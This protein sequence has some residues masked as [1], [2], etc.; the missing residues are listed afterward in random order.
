MHE[1]SA[2]IFAKIAIEKGLLDEKKLEQARMLQK[3]ARKDG[4]AVPLDKAC[5]E[6]EILTPEQVRG[7]ER[8]LRYYVARKADKI[9]A[10][11]ATARKFVDADTA[12][13]CLQK[14]HTEFYKKKRL[15]RLSKLLLGL[16]A[17]T[18]EQDDEVRKAVQG[19]LSP[20]ES[21][22]EMKAVTEAVPE[23]APLAAAEEKA[24]PV[25]AAAAEKSSVEPSYRSDGDISDVYESD[26]P[27]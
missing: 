22:H 12:E 23:K 15:V 9:Y 2:S 16:D 5:L 21:H 13:H 18:S 1:S 4:K 8:G 20:E 7:L 24:E 17:I 14:Q 19:R 26:E 27:K 10:K 6:L 11:L 25:A 3:L